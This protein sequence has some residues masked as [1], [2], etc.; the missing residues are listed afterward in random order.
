M[1]Y[2][3]LFSVFLLTNSDYIPRFMQCTYTVSSFTLLLVLLLV[4]VLN[5]LP[6]PLLLHELGG[7]E[8]LKMHLDGLHPNFALHGNVFDTHCL[9]TGLCTRR[10]NRRKKRCDNL[11]YS[12][13]AA[14]TTATT[15]LFTTL[16][17]ASRSGVA[18][19]STSSTREVGGQLPPEGEPGCL[20][21]TCSRWSRCNIGG[22]A[23]K[24]IQCGVGEL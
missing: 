12:A 10:V 15:L 4:L 18:T 19:P 14:G 21:L 5:P 3:R 22:D 17:K 16:K 8:I 23:M 20:Q 6:T 1:Y 11:S 7:G 9:T 13:T 24:S 2:R